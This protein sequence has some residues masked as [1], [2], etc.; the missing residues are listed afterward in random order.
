MCYILIRDLYYSNSMLHF[1]KASKGHR[2]FCIKRLRNMKRVDNSMT[3]LRDV[4]I[5]HV[6]QLKQNI[7]FKMDSYGMVKVCRYCTNTAESKNVRD[8]HARALCKFTVAM[9]VLGHNLGIPVLLLTQRVP[10][11]LFK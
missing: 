10:V 9:M 2:D 7:I 11:H 5:N 8:R 4:K 6:L 3:Y 1:A